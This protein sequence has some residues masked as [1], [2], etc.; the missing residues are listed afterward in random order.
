MAVLLAIGFF[1]LQLWRPLEQTG[2]NL[3][4]RLR[5]PLEWDDRIA[6]IGIDDDTLEAYQ[7]F[8]LP[9][10]RYTELLQSLDESYPVVVGFDILFIEP[11]P[12]D[13]SLAAAM[14]QLGTVVLA[15]TW[16]T[17]TGD[18]LE[19]TPTLAEGAANQGQILHQRN[20]DGI[21]REATLWVNS[22]N[23][24][25]P[26]LT[27]AMV[28]VENFL[29]DAEGKPPL[30]PLPPPNQSQERQTRLLN[31]VGDTANF[32]Q[33]YSFLDVAEGRIK[34]EGLQDKLILVGF[35]ATATNDPLQTPLN[36][37]PP[38]S[39]VYYHATVL[40]NLLQDR[41]LE[42]LPLWGEMLL[43]FPMGIFTAILLSRRP[44][45]RRVIFV[46]V[47]PIAWVLVAL[48]L[49]SSRH[50]WLPVA[51]PIGTMLLSVGG[52]QLREQWE[53]QQ[54]MQL[55]EKYVSP[56]TAN[57]IWQQKDDFFQDGELLATQLEA[58]VLFMDIR[59]FTSIS[60]QIPPESVFR[61]LNRYLDTMTRCIM[62]HGGVVDKYIGDAIMAVFGV[63]FPR[64][65]EAEVQQ[66]A[67]NAI[68]ASLTMCRH[69]DQL[70]QHLQQEGLPT[71]HIG[72]GIHS[73]SVMAGSLGGSQ[74]LNYSIVGDTVNVAARLETLNKQVSQ[75]RPYPILL[76][77]QTFERVRDRYNGQPITEIQ[78]R[79]RQELTQVYT[80]I[81]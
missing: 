16:E 41:F 43:L 52:V 34:P 58:T 49:L 39:G 38:T 10:D 36:R 67:Y 56:E 57:V 30:V 42:K 48:L 71:I 73:G 4:F 24:S 51:A 76:S 70:N 77:S 63:P 27:L 59:G 25:I 37:D 15:R 53:K 46:L 64:T 72:I 78:L 28:E 23:F 81:Q 22:P 31:W 61:W 17:T 55:F 75:D 14:N 1:P 29:R 62:D 65:T 35:T 54:L 19:P 68:A 32:P 50:F 18:P 66:D 69:L 45:F 33:Y 47:F 60:E 26:N 80:I 12:Q 44:L 79:G 8:P 11:T 21:T 9:R 3:L 40:D 7:T 74:R 13:A 2:Y 20:P 5:P 6:I